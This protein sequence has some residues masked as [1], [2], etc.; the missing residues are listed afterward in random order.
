MES[1]STSRQSSPFLVG[2]PI[3]PKSKTTVVLVRE[4][5]F[6]SWTAQY[7]YRYLGYTNNFN[8]LG[9]EAI[10]THATMDAMLTIG[11]IDNIY[12]ERDP[13]PR[14]KGPQFKKQWSQTVDGGKLV[15]ISDLNAEF[16]SKF[17]IDLTLRKEP[18]HLLTCYSKQFAQQL[19]DVLQRPVVAYADNLLSFACSRDRRLLSLETLGDMPIYEKDAYRL[20]LAKPECFQPKKKP[21]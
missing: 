14:I 16:K 13:N 20:E 18:L 17:G 2:E 6:D 7:L 8:G 1:K 19:A 12:L 3:A 9:L 15:H 21:L 4:S 11:K 5:F 10:D